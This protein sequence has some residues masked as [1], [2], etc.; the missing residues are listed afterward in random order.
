M[1]FAATDF[2]PNTTLITSNHAALRDL[3]RAATAADHT[4]LDQAMAGLRLAEPGDLVRFLGIHLAARAGIE[5]W[6]A[7]HAAP[8]WVPPAQ[9][10]L[11]AADLVALGG[12]PAA[13][14][15]PRFVPGEEADW[16]GPAYV[17]AGSH[18]GN[19]L[20]LA[21][22]GPALAEDARGFLVGSA[23]QDYW[24]RLRTLLSGTPGPDGGAA[25]VRGAQATFAHFTRCVEMFRLAKSAAA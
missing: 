19:R 22:A 25:A 24:R 5:S 16:L 10:G 18:L 3:L 20:L 12:L 9:T 2:G 23:M 4:L 1:A 13:F 11:I 14:P 6:L 17:I 8:G 21:Q 7:D 15:A